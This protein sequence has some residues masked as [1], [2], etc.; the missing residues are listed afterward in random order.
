[1]SITG[2]EALAGLQL[3][4]AVAKADG[5]MT[6]EEHAVIVDALDDAEMPDGITTGALIKSSYDVDS[7][8]AQIASQDARDVAFGACITMAHANRVCLPKEQAILDKIEVAWAVPEE[9]KTLL[10]RVLQE[11]KDTVWLTHLAPTADRARREAL[12]KADAALI[13][14]LAAEYK[15]GR[16]TLADYERKIVELK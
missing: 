15:A 11:A 12:I 3:L 13:E 9:K 6:P 8:I 14:E 4:V 1:M 2:K 7:L 5:D 16:I 10:G